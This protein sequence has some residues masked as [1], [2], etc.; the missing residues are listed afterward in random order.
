MNDNN[1]RK[2]I[3]FRVD[4]ETHK[5]LKIAAARNGVTMKQ[6]LLELLRKELK[7]VKE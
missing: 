1:E 7:N 4:P 2:Q 6:F 3:S 5:K